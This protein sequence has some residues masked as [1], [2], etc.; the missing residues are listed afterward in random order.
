MNTSCGSVSFVVFVVSTTT[1]DPTA[2]N[3]T[4][5]DAKGTKSHKEGRAQH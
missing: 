2:S 3:E 1:S 4:T 5:K